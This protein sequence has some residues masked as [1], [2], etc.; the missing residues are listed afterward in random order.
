[1]P[2]GRYRNIIEAPWSYLISDDI[3][4]LTCEPQA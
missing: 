4:I 3:W 2:F 1:V